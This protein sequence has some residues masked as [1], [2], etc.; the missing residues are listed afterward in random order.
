MLLLNSALSTNIGNTKYSC[1][2]D[3]GMS[4]M[5]WQSQ[6][7]HA[8]SCNAHPAQ[9]GQQSQLQALGQYGSNSWGMKAAQNG[10]IMNSNYASHN[11]SS[12]TN[13]GPSDLYTGCS[14]APMQ[15]AYTTPAANPP[16]TKSQTGAG[17]VPPSH[18]L[19]LR[20]TTSMHLLWCRTDRSIKMTSHT[21][22]YAI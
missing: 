16:T 18:S 17:Y 20:S 3:S 2:S 8:T 13:Y 7:Q 19:L 22:I 5:G 6:H 1:Y 4:T 11:G 12:M 9:S 15:K 14:P 10:P 21:L